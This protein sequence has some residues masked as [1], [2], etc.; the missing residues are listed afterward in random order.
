M[1]ADLPPAF[2]ASGAPSGHTIFPTFWGFVVV[3]V[4]LGVFVV[5]G[6]FLHLAHSGQ[7]SPTRSAPRLP[8]TGPGQ[9]LGGLYGL[10]NHFLKG[11]KKSV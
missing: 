8:C 4:V 2:L 11:K 5:V 7:W 9:P 3:F 6:F 10:R 1:E